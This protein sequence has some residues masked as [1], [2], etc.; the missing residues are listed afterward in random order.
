MAVTFNG[1]RD[2]LKE[3]VEEIGRTFDEP[4]DDWLP[5]VFLISNRGKTF[6]TVPVFEFMQNEGTKDLLAR[7]VIPDL[8]RKT[9][10]DVFGF[11]ASA[12]VLKND[13]PE[14]RPNMSDE[15]IEAIKQRVMAEISA[16]GGVK[17][18]PDRSEIVA[19]EVISL[20]RYET[21]TAD[22]IRHDDGP[23]TLAEWRGGGGDKHTESRWSGP[24][25][26][27]MAFQG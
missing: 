21:W 13:G 27:A 24:V 3:A 6:D 18:H 19:L 11:V 20:T 7:V 10:A 4:D 2:H 12:W 15:E 22:I 14:I 1:L 25:R 17:N 9:G 23:P 26:R 16:I 8:I 5:M